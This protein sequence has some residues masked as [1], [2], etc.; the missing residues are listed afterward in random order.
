MK[1]VAVIGLASLFLLTG[2]GNTV[3]CKKDGITYEGKFKDNNITEI[4]V[5][6]KADS[7][8]EA[9]D[10]CELAKTFYGKKNVKCSGK[11]VS[12]TMKAPKGT[13]A[14]KEDFKKEYCK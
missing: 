2:C 8:K 4:T 9:K 3:K 5:S 7:K 6:E 14:T 13:K 12:I 10:T 11:T 1:K